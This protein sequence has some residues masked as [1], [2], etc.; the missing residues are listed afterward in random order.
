[1]D[2]F[3]D[4]GFGFESDN[5]GGDFGWGDTGFSQTP[6]FQNG[7]NELLS[8]IS[9][10]GFEGDEVTVFGTIQRQSDPFIVSIDPD[11]EAGQWWA[12][13]FEQAFNE[14][15]MQLANQSRE[16]GISPYGSAIGSDG[17]IIW[18]ENMRQGLTDTEDTDVSG[19][20]QENDIQSG[21]L[22]EQLLD[23]LD[24]MQVIPERLLEDPAIAKLAKFGNVLTYVEILFHIEQNLSSRINGTYSDDD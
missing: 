9:G 6:G 19:E 15:L 1:M 24:P 18:T 14:N 4:S 22:A 13:F 5:L 8:A 21:P 17:N 12:N 3:D 7:I 2:G 23:A 16:S 10:T 20:A 11:S